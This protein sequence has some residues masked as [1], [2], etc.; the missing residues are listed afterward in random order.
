MNRRDFIMLVPLAVAAGG[1]RTMTPE[2]KLAVV[3]T[4]AGSAA[5][6]GAIYVLPEGRAAITAAQQA[7][8]GLLNKADYDPARFSAVIEE[9]LRQLGTDALRGDEAALLIGQGLVI[10]D[11]AR[12]QLIDLQ[13][14]PAWVPVVMSAVESGLRR[15]LDAAPRRTRTAPNYK[16]K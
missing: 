1:C 4:L 2:E 13:R 12:Q 10:F 7:L 6:S 5:Y 9:L 15:A 3:A 14:T 11:V 8:A 16:I